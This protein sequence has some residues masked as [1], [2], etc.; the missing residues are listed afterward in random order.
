LEKLGEP[1]L[2][3]ATTNYD[4]SA[5]SALASLGLTVDA[6][7]RQVPHRT[8]EF[9]AG[10]LVGERQGTT[11]VIHLHGAVGWYER[12][13]SVGEHPA[14]QP[15]N[16]SLGAP[17][18]LYPDP[19]KDPTSD[20]TVSELWAELEAALVVV[21]AVLVIG[22]SLHDPPLV[23]ALRR[24]ARSKPVVISFCD[25]DPETVERLIPASRP[26]E[27][28]FGPQMVIDKPLQKLLELRPRSPRVKSG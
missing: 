21:D 14:D 23:R 28:E 12:N 1:E 5:E 19:D 15:F 13:G 27:L 9:E 4:R 6:G 26:V 2:I 7:F 25:G 11:P 8:P 22:H 10:G 3:V 24:I 16:S 17:V 20:A 18:V